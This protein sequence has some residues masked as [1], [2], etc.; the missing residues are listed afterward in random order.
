ML[1]KNKKYF[2]LSMTLITTL[3]MSIN[4]FAFDNTKVR[5]NY[6]VEYHDYADI[7]ETIKS[8]T[9][10]EMYL[11]SIERIKDTF[12][13]GYSPA[14]AQRMTA[15]QEISTRIIVSVNKTVINNYSSF[16]SVPS[17]ISYSEYNDSYKTW[18]SGTLHLQKAERLAGSWTA[19]FSGTI[20][21]HI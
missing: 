3:L 18:M 2:V 11:Y 7:E 5:D 1:K 6:S 17:T 8:E 10:I 19:T 16:E 13:A 21:G 15:N 9:G 14:D 4:V 20:I 12:H